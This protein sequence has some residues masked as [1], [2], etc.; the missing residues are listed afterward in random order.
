MTNTVAPHSMSACRDLRT[1][2]LIAPIAIGTERP[3]FTWIPGGEQRAWE[4]DVEDAAGE[5]VWRAE[6]TGFPRGPVVYDGTALDANGAYAWRVR[7]LTSEGW[8][9]WAT[10]TFGV[11][12]LRPGDWQAPWVEPAQAGT[13]IERWTLLDWIRGGG[14]ATPEQDRLRPANLVRQAIEIDRPVV[15]ARLYATARGIYQATVNGVTVGDEV[16]AP[17][18]DSYLHRVSVQ[19]Y[20]ITAALRPGENVIGIAVADGWWTGRIGITGSSA[21]FGQ[22]TA[23]AWQA[24]IDYADGATEVMMLGARARSSAG[25]WLYA[26]LFVGECYDARKARPGWDAVGFD[27]SDWQP[28]RVLEDSTH[29]L[30][31]FTGEP[32]RRVG[33]V[34]PVDVRET[35]E[36][37][38]IDFGQVLVG[39]VRLRLRGL[40]EGRRIT[41]EH[42]EVLT[43][44]AA[45]FQ[46]IVGINKEQADVFVSSGEDADYEPA[47]TF[48]GFR[49]ARIVGLDA[50]PAPA[51]VRAVV[52]ASDLAD[53]G[54]FEC[55]DPRLTRL[56]RN[57]VWSQRGNFV[58]I[59]T[60]CP[61]RERAGWTGDMQVFAPAATNNSRVLPFLERWLAN[62]RAD[63][64]SD[65]AVPIFSPWSPVNSDM[66]A[67]EGG[68]AAVSRAAGWSDAIALVPWTLYERYGDPRVLEENWPAMLRWID[69]QREVA[70]TRVPDR[71][72]STE[73]DPV[74]RDRQALLYNSDQNF[75]DWLAP[76]TL[77][78]RP[79][80]EAIGIA[81]ALT[82]EYI[83]P[84]Y[85]AQ[86][87]TVAARAAEILG[88]PEEAA[89]LAARA[90][91][92]RA[93]FAAEYVDVSGGLPVPLQGLYVLAL[94]FDMIP[95]DRRRGAAARLAELVRARGDR[96]DTGFL[97]TP[98]L[99]DVLWETGYRDLARRVLWQSEPPSWLYAVDRGATT[100]W[101]NWAA[102]APDGTPS[103]TSFNHYAF[104]CVDDWLFRRIAG[105]RPTAPGYAEV[106]IEPDLDCGLSWVRAHV[107]TPRGRIQLAWERGRTL[108][109][110]LPPGVSGRVRTGDDVVVVHEGTTLVALGLA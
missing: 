26:D 66:A 70:R 55:S 89:D 4:L 83:G 61:Q 16:L 9:A 47:F 78:G 51:D 103:A 92:V 11:A 1:E 39:R 41:I 36:G 24:H 90:A 107:D 44:D 106:V 59:P 71:L 31:P 73:L 95:E 62:V 79:V 60:D 50:L 67:T 17:G 29:T 34:A 58:S 19:C 28:V 105:I 57:A 3:R 2:H 87:L 80:H 96:L 63:Q 88:R 25:P 102:I 22:R 33:E 93:A 45:W 104:G 46:N 56:H 97:G 15:R 37:A 38:L 35:D 94:A 84:M 14:P 86:T 77:E 72:A 13:L 98:H 91:E 76:S 5:T 30:V 40:P 43:A 27:A 81:P 12:L 110:S 23:V 65:G 54:S 20:D 8:T 109:L 7:S 75:G 74:T 52:L 21:Q 100:M 48:H 18:F 53:A 68:I 6:G 69:Y 32:V 101:E 49:Y 64:F 10:S 85:Q 42:T 108:E 99:L 82:G